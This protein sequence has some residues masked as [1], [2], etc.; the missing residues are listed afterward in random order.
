[1]GGHQGYEWVDQYVGQQIRCLRQ[2]YRMSQH[3]LAKSIGM[4]YQQIQKYEL[5][6]NRVSASVLFHIADVLDVPVAFLLPGKEDRPD[7]LLGKGDES[8]A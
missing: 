1:M 4:T 5:A 2:K 7:L 8:P 6:R 3:E